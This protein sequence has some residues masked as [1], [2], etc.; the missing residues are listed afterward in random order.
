MVRSF[1]FR[2]HIRSD[3]AAAVAVTL[4]P[5]LY[6]LP[7]LLEGRVLCPDDGLLQNVPFRVAAAGIIRSGHLPLWDPYI[8]SG[9]PLLATSQVG[10]F[11]PLNWFYLF[12]STPTATNL[13][14][15][16]T[17]MVA[18][19]GA[20]LYAR[21]IGSS[22]AGA[23]V[24]SL[25]FTFGGAAIGQIAH[26]NIVQTAAVMPWVLWSVEHYAG[27]GTFKRGA[28][29]AGSIAVQFFAGHQQAFVNSLLVVTAYVVVMAI[30]KPVFRKRYL[31]SLGFIGAGL[32]LAAVQILPTFELLRHS[33]RSAA[34]YEFFTSFS[35]PRRFILTFLAP[36]VLGGGDGRLFRAP[37][38]GPPFYPEMVG[39]VGALTLMLAIIAVALKPDTRAKFWA[40][41]ALVCLVLAFGAYAPFGFY[42]VIYYVPLLNLFRVPARHL[43]EVDFALAVLAGRGLTVLARQK[44][45]RRKQAIAL[46]SAITILMFTVLAVTVLRPSEFH[47]ARALPV[48]IL[49]TP[50]LFIPLLI[51]ALS[52]FFLWQTARGRR[53]AT[54]WLFV[55]LIVDLC[56]WGQSAGWYVQSPHASDDYFH[57]PETI[58]T[59]AQFAPKD[60]SSYRILTAPHYFEPSIAP[61]PPSVSH[62][63]D[64]VL[65]TQPDIYMMHGLQ[66]AAGYDGF[67]LD[68]YSQMAGRMKVWGELTDP[69]ITLRGDSREID[70]VNVRYLLSMRRGSNAAVPEA[71]AN[72]GQKYGDYLFAT[73]DLGLPTLPP[74]KRLSFS[75]PKVLVDHIGLVTQL[76]WS[77]NVP[78]NTV[79][80]Q[81]RVHIADGRT[82]EFPVRA[83]ID[84]SE[85]SYD[86][87]DIRA[88]IR[89]RKA[90]VASSYKVEDPHETYEAHTFVTSIALPETATVTGGELEVARDPRWPDLSLA[91]FRISLINQQEN[92]TYALTRGM[93][94]GENEA[95]EVKAD[96]SSARWKLRAQTPSVDIY[97]NARPLPRAWLVPEA[98]VLNESAMLEVIRT[99]RLADGSKWDPATTG[100]IESPLMNE[101][102]PN[103]QG[104]AQITR[105]EPNRIDVKTKA[106]GPSLLVLGENHYPGWRTYVDGRRVDTLRIDY[107]LRGTAV[108]AGE[109]LVE[110]SY[111]PKL[112]IIGAAISLLV[113][114]LLVSGIV[115]ERHRAGEAGGRIKPGT[116]APGLMSRRLA[117]SRSGR[118]PIDSHRLAGDQLSPAS[119][120][121]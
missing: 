46:L 11:Y 71:F 21:Q 14:L 75:V 66:N 32:L 121:R 95:A 3:R 10:I 52:A 29:L 63:T 36:Y 113:L 93:V 88:R 112:V 38:V 116:Q 49:R 105:Y 1:N 13:M 26:I 23:A 28:I 79:V 41:V 50:E 53:G 96:S 120:A 60:P 30:S 55:L 35:M 89:H 101:V 104:S 82:L 54:L 2:F 86:R 106:D 114:V 24:T 83:G 100:L 73:G 80:A 90:T 9:M 70:L 99:G 102:T 51:A 117:S 19:L 76:A 67:G 15:I 34:T 6:F 27:A 45:N 109:H 110:F 56:V 48:T 68:R 108:P 72:A 57:Q 87:A 5:L 94:T 61:I 103:S 107:N 62:S 44:A 16:A 85:W 97:E 118:Q 77:E 98:R 18:A 33:E 43:M 59:L 39:Y 65:W 92:K 64:W 40:A 12:F 69:D 4:A 20:Y 84:T 8:F 37:Y 91:V 42:R 25:V 7:A 58:A 119:R 78:D 47:L 81:L 74:G 31:I 17:Y 115:I 111:Q 22:I